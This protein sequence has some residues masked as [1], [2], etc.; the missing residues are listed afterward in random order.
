MVA[1]KLP[2]VLQIVL[3]VVKVLLCVYGV[4][5]G[6]KLFWDWNKTQRVLIFGES[7]L[8]HIV[9]H[10]LELLAKRRGRSEEVRGKLVPF[11]CP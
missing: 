7:Q 4:A 9:C 6:R 11:V 2:I 3:P 1:I 5:R 10:R 8:L